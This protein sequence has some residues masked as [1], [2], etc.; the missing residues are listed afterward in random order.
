MK[1]VKLVKMWGNNMSNYQNIGVL[2]DM[3]RNG[4][5]TVPQVKR[6]IDL[7]KKMGYNCL[8]LYCED[9]FE[10]EGEPYF[11][12]LRG[13]YS[14]AEIQELDAYAISKGI[15]LIP[16]V[17]TL[18]HFTAMSKVPH[19]WDLFDID[20]ILM[21]GDE[22]VYAF[23]DRMFAS[24][25]KAFS[26]RQINIGMDEAHN[27]GLGKYLNEHGY[28]DR[29]KILVEHLN[30]VNEIAK[31]YGFK[32]HMWSDMFFRLISGGSYE[33]NDF[34][35]LHISKE[36][37]DKVPE[38]VAITYWTYARTDK[39][40]YDIMFD[41]HN[42]FGRE[43]WFAGGAMTWEG[44]APLN[45]YSLKSS[46]AAMESAREYG[47]KNVIFTVW[48]DNG[49][50]CSYF[51]VLPMLYAARQFADGN[52]DMEKIKAGFKE[53]LGLDFDVFM[54]LD[55]PSMFTVDGKP[56]ENWHC[57]CATMFYND[58][59]LGWRDLEYGAIDP[60][61]F[62]DYAKTLAAD[63]K[64]AGEYSVV[65]ETMSKL[66]SYLEYKAPIGLKTREAYKAKDKKALKNMIKYYRETVKRLDAFEK[67]FKKQWMW[68]NKAFGWEIQEIRIGGTRAR[69]LDCMQRLQLYVSGKIDKIEELEAEILPFKDR[70]GFMFHMYTRA[71][72]PCNI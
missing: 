23:L 16:C 68:E 31:K 72:S 25:A 38:D 56:W 17:Q 5:M 20:D 41:R 53:T 35:D 52:Y 15:E 69:I 58:C 54:H 6:Y 50:E 9:T 21:I 61:P 62:A 71:I 30:R 42:E 36:I 12:Y 45:W 65:F 4:V 22:R 39:A 3:S 10:I 8:E 14:I 32:C 19:Y 64:A 57:L 28:Q 60:M 13:G 2:L 34:K 33:P 1:R 55:L 49:K 63:A 46:K 40:E 18:A 67:V 51:S 44:F 11:G 27:V 48:G 26:S 47:I 24:L 29:S 43:V 37:A 59:F 70:N 66:C 7:I